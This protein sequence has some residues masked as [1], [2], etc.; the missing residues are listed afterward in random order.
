MAI[1]EK[2]RQPQWYYNSSLADHGWLNSQLA[3]WKITLTW[4]SCTSTQTLPQSAVTFLL[5]AIKIYQ[6][7]DVLLIVYTGKSHKKQTN[8]C[9]VF[10]VPDRNCKSAQKSDLGARK[11]F[12][13]FIN[14]H[15]YAVTAW[16]VLYKTR[17]CSLPN[18]VKKL[19]TTLIKSNI[20]TT[21]N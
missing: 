13:I 18:S 7:T 17:I 11:A 6:T 5:S 21:N 14:C 8:Y 16:A 19:S 20:L 9:D 4:C 1:D 15:K 2:L 12:A 10:Q 3:F